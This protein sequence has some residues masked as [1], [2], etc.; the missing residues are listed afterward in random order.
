MENILFWQVRFPKSLSLMLEEQISRASQHIRKL[1]TFMV[2]SCQFSNEDAR[3]NL[4][5]FANGF[6]QTGLSLSR[7]W[8]EKFFAHSNEVITLF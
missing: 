5:N 4:L 6:A 2:Y 7:I 3:R 1:K 8:M